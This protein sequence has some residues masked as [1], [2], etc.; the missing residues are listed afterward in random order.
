MA[1][2]TTK[3]DLI[4]AASTNYEKLMGLLDSLSV[5]QLNGTFSFDIDKEKG[6]HW[7]RDKNIHDVLIHLYEWQ[8]LLLDWVEANQKG[9]TKQFLKE[10]YNWKSYGAMNVEFVEKHKDG[11]Y[12]EALS[13]LKESHDK[14]MKLAEGFSN[15]E[16]FA[17]KV[18][19]WVGGS[20]LGSYFV[21][22][23]AS[24]YDWAIKKIRKYKKSI[25]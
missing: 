3:E 18:F 2:P 12:D 5:E 14:V 17:K 15:E 21:S 24:H 8:Q 1:R 9:E 16:L 7:Q 20:T 22:T 11:S 10:G 25:G 4:Q 6:D 23:T 13:L 19:P